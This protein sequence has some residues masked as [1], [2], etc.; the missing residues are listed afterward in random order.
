ME[1]HSGHLEIINVVGM[2]FV[3]SGRSLRLE[4]IESIPPHG[5]SLIT[6]KNVVSVRL[7]QAGGDEYPLIVIDLTWRAVPTEEKESVLR[8]NQFPFVDE[9][10]KPLTPSMP[11]VAVHLEGAI[12]GDI[13]AE[14]VSISPR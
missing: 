4:I 3:D 14:E 6:L 7:F 13:L 11:L 12:V 8:A 1:E 9:S 10:G 2:E 5:T